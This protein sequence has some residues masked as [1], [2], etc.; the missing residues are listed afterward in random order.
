MSE[1]KKR[2]RKNGSEKKKGGFKKGRKSKLEEGISSRGKGRYALT[3]SSIHLKKDREPAVKECL[4]AKRRV[5]KGDLQ[6]VTWG[7]IQTSFNN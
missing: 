1:K 7:L 6:S 3:N 4:F 5:R 2:Y